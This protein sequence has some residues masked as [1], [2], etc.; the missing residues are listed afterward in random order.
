MIIHTKRWKAWSRYLGLGLGD[1]EWV[2]SLIKI[3]CRD[4]GDRAVL[5]VSCSLRARLLDVFT[6]T[7]IYYSAVT[8]EW[9]RVSVLSVSVP[10]PLCT[11]FGP[12]PSR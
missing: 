6:F 5:A 12:S 3:V 9:G 4:S 8:A 2:L 1:G 11:L 10:L 7:L